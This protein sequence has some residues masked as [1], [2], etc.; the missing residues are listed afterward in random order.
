MSEPRGIYRAGT[1]AKV[2]DHVCILLGGIVPSVV[3][4][5][6]ECPGTLRMVGDAYIHNIMTGEALR[7]PHWKET[8]LELH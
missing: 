5:S 8:H 4:D 6:A 3:R 1:T 7:F 2:G